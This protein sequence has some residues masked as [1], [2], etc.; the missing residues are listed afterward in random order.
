MSDEV[1]R[2]ARVLRDGLEAYQTAVKFEITPLSPM[3]WVAGYMASHGVTLA[4][5]VPLTP[6]AAA[7]VAVKN[8]FRKANNKGIDWNPG[9]AE[10]FARAVLAAGWDG[11]NSAPKDEHGFL[12]L[13]ATEPNFEGQ[14]IAF[15]KAQLTALLAA[16]TGG[17]A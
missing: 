15:T 12:W 16:L 10:G 3:E 7:A 8:Q 11:L 6:L 4:A 5:P 17:Q 2:L 9:E 13:P 14:K 1:E